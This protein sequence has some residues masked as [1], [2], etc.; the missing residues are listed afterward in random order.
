[1][2]FKK[3]IPL[4]LCGTFLVTGCKDKV[5]NRNQKTKKDSLLSVDVIKKNADDAIFDFQYGEKAVGQIPSGDYSYVGNHSGSGFYEYRRNS[6]NKYVLYSFYKSAFLDEASEDYIPVEQSGFVGGYA[7]IGSS[8]YDGTGTKIITLE[9]PD[10]YY[11][12]GNEFDEDTKKVTV[13]FFDGKQR[14][15]E[16]TPGSTP[17]E[18]EIDERMGGIEDTFISLEDYGHKDYSINFVGLEAQIFEKEKL[19]KKIN[20]PAEG[21]ADAII[22]DRLYYIINTMMPSTEKKDFDFI[23]NGMVD[24]VKYKQEIISVDYMK[25]K[26]YSIQSDYVIE[27][28]TPI[29]DKEEK[30]TIGI[31]GAYE[32]RKDKTI[33]LDASR[34]FMVDEKLNIHE[35]ITNLPFNILNDDVRV[36]TLDGKTHYLVNGNS[37]NGYLYNSDFELV[38]DFSGFANMSFSKNR[39]YIKASLGGYYG[40]MKLDG[41]VVVPFEFNRIYFDPDVSSTLYG[42]NGGTYFALTKGADGKFAQ[43]ADL[44]VVDLMSNNNYVKIRFDSGINKLYS[45]EGQLLNEFATDETSV[46]VLPMTYFDAMD[47]RLINASYTKSG[48][49]NYLTVKVNRT[50][51]Q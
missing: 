32:L 6:D 25:N 48:A 28:I 15:I 26:K 4:L 3:M 45:P 19:V 2:N 49:T 38:R 11:Y 29:L 37:Y 27:D 43:T 36:C 18:L 13:T 23:R 31:M 51:I 41:T 20:V 39:E 22:G 44:T 50:Q 33:N 10:E 30:Y 1:M 12:I 7:K 42:Y 24:A 17:T 16:Y 9:H 46:N 40:I 8:V 35:E 14:Q 21:G 34:S 5:R 47:L